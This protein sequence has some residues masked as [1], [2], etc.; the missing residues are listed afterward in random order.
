MAMNKELNKKLDCLN[1]TVQRL[2][3]R[4]DVWFET[5]WQENTK[6]GVELDGCRKKEEDMQSQI[7]EADKRTPDLVLK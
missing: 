7:K 4:W 1:E 2:Q 6:L 3:L 5:D